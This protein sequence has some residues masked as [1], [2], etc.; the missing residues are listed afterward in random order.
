[1]QVQG[2]PS[3]KV[4]YLEVRLSNTLYILVTYYTYW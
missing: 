1:V 4:S 3:I 2:F